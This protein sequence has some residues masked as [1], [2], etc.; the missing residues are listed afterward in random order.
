[1]NVYFDN[2]A[3]TQVRDEVI[4]KFQIYLKIVLE[5]HLLHI[6]LEEQQNHT[7]K[8]QEKKLLKF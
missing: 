7:L 1:M 4:S 5:I 8:P 6:P 2:A 3:T